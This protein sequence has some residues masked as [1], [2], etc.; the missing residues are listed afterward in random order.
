MGG[1]CVGHY[2]IQIIYSTYTNFSAVTKYSNINDIMHV[3]A[4]YRVL[5]IDH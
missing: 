4:K 1:V 2:C 5:T 3:Q